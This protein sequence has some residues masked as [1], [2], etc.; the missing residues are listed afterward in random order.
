[1]LVL[2]TGPGALRDDTGRLIARNDGQVRWVDTWDLNDP[3]DPEDDEFLGTELVK[4]S[5]GTNDDI[6]A[7]SVA[8]LR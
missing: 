4:E 2:A 8:A 6:C 7:A 1:V 5:T 3:E